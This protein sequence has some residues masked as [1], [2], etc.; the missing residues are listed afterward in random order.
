MNNLEVKYHTQKKELEIDLLNKINKI[1]KLELEK[2]ETKRL[3]L[4]IYLVVALVLVVIVLIVMLI[5]KKSNIKLE[6]KNLE[7]N[8]LNATKDKFF[9]IISHDLKNPMSAFRNITNSLDNNMNELNKDS[10]LKVITSNHKK[11]VVP[12]STLNSSKL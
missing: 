10:P 8:L 11:F 9:S 7:L 3:F 5:I 4:N 2:N 1:N 6:K 12:G